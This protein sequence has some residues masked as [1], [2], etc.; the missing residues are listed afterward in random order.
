MDFDFNDCYW[1]DSIMENIY[2]DRSN[3]G[4]NDSIEITVEWYEDKSKAKLIFKQVRLFKATMNFGIIA[5][6]TIDTA[7]IAPPDDPDRLEFYRRWKGMFDHVAL[8]SYVIET[9]S[10]GGTLK[11]L[12]GSVEMVKL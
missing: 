12:A 10:T 3:P 11:I 8:N 4:Y 5:H 7:Y 1:H 9:L 6:E 2:I